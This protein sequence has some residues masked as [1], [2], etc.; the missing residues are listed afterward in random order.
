MHWKGA[1][2]MT[3]DV[4]VK[5]ISNKPYT[6]MVGTT[7]YPIRNEKGDF[8]A[9]MM[10][11]NREIY[12]PPYD[13]TNSRHGWID[14]HMKNK[15]EHGVD[16]Y[17][18]KQTVDDNTNI[19]PEERQATLDRFLGA[20]TLQE[21]LMVYEKAL[22]SENP[23]EG[24]QAYFDNLIAE[25]AHLPEYDNKSF[26]NRPITNIKRAYRGIK[27]GKYPDA[28]NYKDPQD[29]EYKT[30]TGPNSYEEKL[31]SKYEL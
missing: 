27:E 3:E 16:Y 13:A 1:L 18:V 12:I 2:Q 24:R 30:H 20:P 23:G 8:R 5:N 7:H 6:N 21:E 15:Q 9:H 28:S 11:D 10:T 22:R 29:F 14:N 19:S 26:L 17:D 25:Y 4:G 31:R